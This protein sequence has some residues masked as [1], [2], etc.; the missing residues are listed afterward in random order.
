MLI[1]YI[2]MKHILQP[3]EIERLRS[4]NPL[5]IGKIGRSMN[6]LEL[7]K[8]GRTTNRMFRV[9]FHRHVV[10]PA[11]IV[12]DIRELAR[13]VRYDYA[14]NV[15]EGMLRYMSMDQ[16]PDEVKFKLAVV[17]SV[18]ST[19]DVIPDGLIG[20]NSVTPYINPGFTGDI[21]DGSSYDDIGWRVS[22]NLLCLVLTEE[23]LNQLR[24]GNHDT[25]G[26]GQSEDQEDS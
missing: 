22:Q 15:G 2:D 8:I 24:G 5:E 25:R 18:K 20:A 13:L 26:P 3:F 9:I 7:G 10:T 14:I 1:N 4:M 12:K 6:P 16:L 11:P 19:R 23:T 17:W 21:R